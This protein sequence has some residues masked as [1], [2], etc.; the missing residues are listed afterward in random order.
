MLADMTPEAA[1]IIRL[2]NLVP[3]SLECGFYREIYRSG[4]TVPAAAIPGHGGDRSFCTFIYYLLPEGEVSR[5]HRLKSDEMWHFLA[6]GPLK[7]VELDP[8]TG[9]ASTT[10]LGQGI[11]VGQGLFHLFKAGTWFGAF[12]EKGAGYSL[13]GCAVSP[14]FEI[15]DFEAG[16]R[17]ELVRKFPRARDLIVK[18][19]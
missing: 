13:V 4:G 9:G 11:N 1:E 14:G 5:L 7:L 18:L 8:A 10:V 16:R 3:H 17:D 19:S 6:G 12:P 15:G 2:L